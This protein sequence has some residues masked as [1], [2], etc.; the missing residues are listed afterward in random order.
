[1]LV[2]IVLLASTVEVENER[3]ND[4]RLEVCAGNKNSSCQQREVLLL[5]LLL[6]LL[7]RPETSSKIIADFFAVQLSKNKKVFI[8]RLIK[9][10]IRHFD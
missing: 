3:I 2:T 6:L 7:L 10:F 5:L 9:K 8:K 4:K 1:M